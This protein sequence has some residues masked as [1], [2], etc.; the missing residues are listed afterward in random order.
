M[1]T[2]KE[3]HLTQNCHQIRLAQL[4]KVDVEH[5]LANVDMRSLQHSL[6]LQSTAFFALIARSNGQ[7]AESGFPVLS[8]VQ[9]GGA[10][11]TATSSYDGPSGAPTLANSGANPTYPPPTIPPT[12][13]A[14]FMQKSSLPSGTVFISAAGVLGLMLVCVILWRLWVT[15][16]IQRRVKKVQQGY[17]RMHQQKRSRLGF[18]KDGVRLSKKPTPFYQQAGT[19]SMISMKLLDRKEEPD[20]PQS[21]LPDKAPDKRS[22]FFSPTASN[23]LP[24]TGLGGVRTSSQYLPSGYY[25]VSAGDRSRNQA[26]SLHEISNAQRSELQEPGS[27]SD[28]P[29]PLLPD[30]AVETLP[31]GSADGPLHEE[32][33]LSWDNRAGSRTP[34]AHLEDIFNLNSVSQEHMGGL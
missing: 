22:L 31:S 18:T 30:I 28:S 10:K 1:R 13:D 2:A 4:E 23:G 8:T 12:A 11:T 15:W 33:S 19:G 34:S 17:A 3:R 5:L 14:P 26:Y 9:L 16:T 32:G 21:L 6:A 7:A 25:P 24:S 29:A 20:N 27:R